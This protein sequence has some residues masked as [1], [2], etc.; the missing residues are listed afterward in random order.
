MGIKSSNITTLKRT[1][2]ENQ[3]YIA[4]KL[5][6]ADSNSIKLEEEEHRK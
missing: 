5:E 3:A 2:T 4:V 6:N 1:N